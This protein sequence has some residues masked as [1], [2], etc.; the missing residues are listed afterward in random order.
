[1]LDYV[2]HPLSPMLGW[3]TGEVLGRFG[4][5]GEATA[6][7]KL[8]HVV[9][10]LPN[11]QITSFGWSS[12]WVCKGSSLHQIQVGLLL[13]LGQVYLLALWQRTLEILQNIF[14]N[15]VQGKKLTWF[16]SVLLGFSHVPTGSN[17]PLV[18]STFH[19][20]F[21]TAYLL[22]SKHQ[23]EK[24]RQPHYQGCLTDSHN[25]PILWS[26]LYIFFS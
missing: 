1:M 22:D 4:S 26:K 9:S 8:T 10:N 11:H 20:P 23:H 5:R 12:S 2:F 17:F 15:K 6:V 3:T 14:V 21:L 13:F 25:C 16:Q 18:S 19:L 7:S 24:Q